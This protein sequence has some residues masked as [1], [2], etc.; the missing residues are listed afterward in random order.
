M[1]TEEMDG[2][3]KLCMP[4]LATI[5]Y[6]LHWHRTIQAEPPVSVSE[7]CICRLGEV[8]GWL[9]A[10]MRIGRWRIVSL[11]AAELVVWLRG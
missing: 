6:S 5:A 11:L 7:T 2:H 3:D 1:K 10:T 8:L 4:Y 9:Q